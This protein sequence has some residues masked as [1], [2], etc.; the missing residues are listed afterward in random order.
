MTRT[1]TLKLWAGVAA[2]ALLAGQA[3]A[4][5]MGLDVGGASV[6]APT[7]VLLAQADEGTE[8]TTDPAPE[9]GGVVDPGDGNEAGITGG[10]GLEA[11]GEEGAGGEGTEVWAGGDPDFCESCGA[12]P[13]DEAVTSEG[14]E[15][16]EVWA[17]GDPDFCE[18][19][20]GVPVDDAEA[21]PMQSGVAPV[22]ETDHVA[23]DATRD[24]D[25]Q[26]RIKAS[27]SVVC[28]D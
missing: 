15:G 2:L 7:G 14:G 8:A 13:I 6:A 24:R 22:A 23:K 20:T 28:Q 12:E 4:A 10:G 1:E 26:G 3:W 18:A 5:P 21:L 17:G 11:I 25:C 19:C 27:S 16:T 9:D